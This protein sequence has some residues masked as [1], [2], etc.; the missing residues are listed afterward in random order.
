MEE[1]KMHKTEEDREIEAIEKAWIEDFNDES[2]SS[3]DEEEENQ[4]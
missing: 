1:I 3:E 2:E 4:I